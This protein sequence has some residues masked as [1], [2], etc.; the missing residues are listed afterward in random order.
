M[1][2]MPP[3]QLQDRV[4]GS[5]IPV[6][7]HSMLIGD[8]HTSFFP[9]RQ[10]IERQ[11]FCPHFCANSDMASPWRAYLT[12]PTCT[13][14]CYSGTWREE[15]EGETTTHGSLMQR[16]DQKSR[17]RV[18]NIIVP[19]PSHPIP[20]YGAIILRLAEENKISGEKFS[21]SLRNS[22]RPKTSDGDV[23]TTETI[24]IP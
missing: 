19:P 21:G 2:L 9:H 13:L 14:L 11:G 17:Q 8:P 22:Y 7:T 1:S 15:S 18:R 20:N 16:Y 5:K 6:R 24:Q 12:P 4:R 10:K 3:Q 23:G